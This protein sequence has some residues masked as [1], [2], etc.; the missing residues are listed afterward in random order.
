VLKGW[1]DGVLE[2]WS[3]EGMEGWRDGGMEGWRDGYLQMTSNSLGVR[4]A[5]LWAEVAKKA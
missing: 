5:F 3:A 4:N 1:R 2:C